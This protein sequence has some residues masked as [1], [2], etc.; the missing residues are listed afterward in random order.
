MKNKNR[1]LY[2]GILFCFFFLLGN[3]NLS[4]KANQEHNSTITNYLTNQFDR[5]AWFFTDAEVISDGL[6]DGSQ[7]SNIAADS[8]GNIHIVWSDDSDFDGA[9]FDTDIFYRYWNSSTDTWSDKKVVSIDSTLTSTNGQVAVDSTGIVYVVWEDNTDILSSGADRDIFFKIYDPAVDLWS[10]PVLVSTDS[11]QL[12]Y[13]TCIAIDSMDNLHVAWTDATNFGGS[14]TDYDIFYKKWFSD[15]QLWSPTIVIS[16][17]STVDSYSPDIKVDDEGNI[18]FVWNDDTDY[19]SAGADEDIF[20]KKYDAQK[21]IFETTQVISTE[22]SISSY[23]P[24]IALDKSGNP[25]IVWYDYTDY[26]GAGTDSDIFFK[27]WNGNLNSWSSTEVVSTESDLAAYAPIVRIDQSNNILVVW[28]DYTNYAGSGDDSDVILKIKN[29][30]TGIWSDVAIVSTES[31]QST[32]MYPSFDI[33][34]NGFIHI[35]WSDTTDYLSS[36]TDLD[37][38][39]KKYVGSSAAP[40]LAEINPVLSTIGDINLDWTESTGASDYYIYRDTMMIWSVENLVPIAKNDMSFYQDTSVANG[41][42]YYAIVAE[43]AYGNSTLSNV[44]F[45]QVEKSNSFLNIS[46]DL[47]IVGGIIIALQILSFI[48]IIVLKRK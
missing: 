28:Y 23:L 7:F 21:D 11:T 30:E 44:E 47:L 15:D 12:S 26:L 17:E 43:N 3:M 42:Y 38:F 9:G 16:T 8:A 6:S 14:G 18:H 32:T 36:G 39:Y 41:N 10:I 35:A 45:V 20:Y 19:E 46:S 37:I 48:G 22:S 40:I 24:S 27:K 25:Y 31:T 5:S 2:L 34:N 33:D 1:L 29:Q 4:L 13:Q